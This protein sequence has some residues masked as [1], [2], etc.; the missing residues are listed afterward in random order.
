MNVHIDPD[1]YSVHQARFL[2]AFDGIAAYWRVVVVAQAGPEM[3][4]EVLDKARHQF[5]DLLA[6]LPYIGGDDNHYTRD[7]V[8]SAGYLALYLVLKRRGWK[9]EKAARVMYDAI[10]DRNRDLP[11][12]KLPPLDQLVK[13]GQMLAERALE[14]RYPGDYV[15]DFVP[16]DGVGFDFGYNFW[17]CATLKLYH[18]WGADEFAPYYCY[19]DFPKSP[20]GLRRTQTLAEGAPFCNHRFKLGRPAEHTWPP[21]FVKQE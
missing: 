1:Y 13:S 3:A 18:A 4:D 5:T 17:E 10:L 12:P 8:E 19:L 15:Y 16:G 14:N 11:P 6:S 9:V 2:A 20:L 21:P 7:L